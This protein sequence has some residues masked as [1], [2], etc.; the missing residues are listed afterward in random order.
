[1][2]WSPSNAPRESHTP[3]SVA[4]DSQFKPRSSGESLSA[5]SQPPARKLAN[6]SLSQSMRRLLRIGGGLTAAPHPLTV[7]PMPHTSEAARFLRAAVKAGLRIQRGQ[8]AGQQTIASL[9]RIKASVQK[10]RSRRTK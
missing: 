5:Q 7:P 8:E 6:L 9:R 4:A 10:T 1:M 2:N 3:L